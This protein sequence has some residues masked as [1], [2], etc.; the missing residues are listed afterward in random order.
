FAAFGVSD[1]EFDQAYDSFPVKTNLRNAKRLTDKAKFPSVPMLLVNGKFMTP[2]PAVKNFGEML[3][4]A[5]ELIARE[6]AA[7]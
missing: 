6:R 2:G 5:D 4:V 3:R 1:E 7:L